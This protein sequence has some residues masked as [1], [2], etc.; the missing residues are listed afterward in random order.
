MLFRGLMVSS[1]SGSVDGLVASHNRGGPYFRELVVPVNPNTTRQQDVRT[2]MATAYADWAGLTADQRQNWQNFAD[3]QLRTNRIGDRRHNSGW[4]EYTRWAVPRLQANATLG[5]S[6]GTGAAYPQ[7]PEAKLSRPPTAT[8]ESGNTVFR[9][10]FDNADFWV[11]DQDN[12]LLLYLCSTRVSPGVRAIRPIKPTINFFRGPYELAA[13]I[14]GDPD[15]PIA[16][17]L[18]YTIA[19]TLT[20]GQRMFWRV[21]LTTDDSG[22]SQPYEGVVI[23]S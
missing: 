15:A 16:D 9:L 14:A 8:L 22:M 1:L 7:F 23:A 3:T 5:F 19:V 21:R 17:H 10:H 12:A 2:A 13:A 6:F 20:A 4:D 11:N 18:D